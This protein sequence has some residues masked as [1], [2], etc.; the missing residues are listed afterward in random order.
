MTPLS[1][2]TLL[3]WLKVKSR[4]SNG[5]R[6]AAP[7]SIIMSPRPSSP[8]GFLGGAGLPFLSYD[9]RKIKRK[10]SRFNSTFT[11]LVLFAAA[12]LGIKR[13]RQALARD[14]IEAL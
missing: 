7:G 13:D 3:I 12:H 10:P 11:A 6:G 8:A 4:D 9:E 1:V 5:W 14:D 2:S